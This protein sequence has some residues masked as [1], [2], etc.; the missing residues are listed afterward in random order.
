MATYG[1]SSYDPCGYCDFCVKGCT[2]CPSRCCETKAMRLENLKRIWKQRR[3]SASQALAIRKSGIVSKMVGQ[4]ACPTHLLQAGGPGD[5][6]RSVQSTIRDPSGVPLRTAPARARATG[7]R[8]VVR[9]PRQRILYNNRSGVDKKHG[10][11]ARYLARKTGGVLRKEQLPVVRSQTARTGQPR[12]RTGTKACANPCAG[13]QTTSQC[14][15]SFNFSSTAFFTPHDSILGIPQ[16]AH[17]GFARA[18]AASFTGTG[19]FGH[20]WSDEGRYLGACKPLICGHEVILLVAG[21]ETAEHSN[22][23]AFG[24][25]L[26]VAGKV[27]HDCFPTLTVINSR[28][29][30]SSSL[31]TSWRSSGFSGH[32]F[33]VQIGARTVPAT[34]WQWLV[35]DAPQPGETAAEVAM[36]RLF[37]NARP[38]DEIIVL[39]EGSDCC[40]TACCNNR[41]PTVLAPGGACPATW[42]GR[43]GD[44]TQCVSS[45]RC[46]SGC[47]SSGQTATY[48]N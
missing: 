13:K 29:R 48:R 35:Q 7:L 19:D 17:P 26:M 32:H 30:E 1:I 12:N 8:Y 16:G 2:R 23:I 46:P 10:S 28:T 3:M 44:N 25:S 36:V 33:T 20:S 5:L 22:T 47:C 15:L 41:I 27:P 21:L 6:I 43:Q 18:A 37:E 39:A 4:S 24:V 42:T 14:G 31:H 40:S 34:Y 11:Y 45:T 9:A 38:T